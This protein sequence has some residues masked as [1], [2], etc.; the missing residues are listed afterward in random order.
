MNPFKVE[1]AVKKRAKEEQ[2]EEQTRVLQYQKTFTTPHGKEV[3]WDILTKCGIFHACYS[4]ELGPMS[5]SE[6]RR[7]IGLELLDDVLR[8][9]PKLFAQI[10]LERSSNARPDSDDSDDN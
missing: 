3:L 5:F 10:L 9:D 6:G 4:Q 8:A 1:R 7:A 2:K